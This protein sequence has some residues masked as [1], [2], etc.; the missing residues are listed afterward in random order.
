MSKNMTGSKA[1]HW[2]GG[3]IKRN[4]LVCNNEFEFDKGDL[5]RET[6]SRL[7][8][9]MSCKAMYYSLKARNS[10]WKGG[11]TPENL[12]MRNSKEAKAWKA[13]V[14]LRDK[15]ICQK[16]GAIEEL[17]VHHIKPFSVFKDLRFMISNGITLCKE[18]HHEVHSKL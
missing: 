12:I 5:N 13:A 11:I 4:C 18:C 15:Y 7:F 8:C 9:S 1:N 3:K 2:Q 17:H 6:P 14:L 10:N 16:C